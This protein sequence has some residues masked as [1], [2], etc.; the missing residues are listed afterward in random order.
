M[1][2]CADLVQVPFP[3][4][5]GGIDVLTTTSYFPACPGDMEVVSGDG[6]LPMAIFELLEYIV[7]EVMGW[8]RWM[9]SLSIVQQH[10]VLTAVVV[11]N[12]SLL[13]CCA[14]WQPSCC[15]VVVVFLFL[16]FSCFFCV[17]CA[18]STMFHLTVTSLCYFSVFV[19]GGF[20]FF[21][22]FLLH[23]QCV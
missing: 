3:A 21:F 7:N 13:L 9:T 14:C 1:T 10:F 5:P 22:F 15:L 17:L 23:D 12:G 11:L 2:V 18:I 19:S 20:V 8:S 16:F 6:P 4:C